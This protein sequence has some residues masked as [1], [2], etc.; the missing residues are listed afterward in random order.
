LIALS[1]PIS[2]LGSFALL[3]FA[4]W[5]A[6]RVLLPVIAMKLGTRIMADMPRPGPL[7][8]RYRCMDLLCSA[9]GP[10]WLQ[11]AWREAHAGSNSDPG[12]VPLELRPMPMHDGRR[13]AVIKC[14][15]PLRDGEAYLL[16]IVLPADP[17]LKTDLPR[18]RVALRIF[19]LNRFGHPGGERT[20]DLCA[21]MIQRG[22]IRHLT[23]NVGA[24]QSIEGFAQAV[25]DK[26]REL[27]W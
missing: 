25:E 4:L 2:W 11:Q 19:V 9:Q 6:W 18:A 15:E 17:S 22:K 7:F 16:A 24:R 26:L 27:G 3:A 14:P 1:G 10:S 5:L 20:T 21:W 13:I 23:Y 12:T 8:F